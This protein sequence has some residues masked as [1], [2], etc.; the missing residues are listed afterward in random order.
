IEFGIAVLVEIHDDAG[1]EHLVETPH[2]AQ[3][4]DGAVRIRDH[5]EAGLGKDMR[6]G[7]GGG[8]GERSCSRNE[9][10]EESHGFQASRSGMPRY[11]ITRWNVTEMG[12]NWVLYASMPGLRRNQACRKST[13]V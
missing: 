7:E 6:M 12:R 3:F 2:V 9:K 8:G 4:A 5:F 13:K 11:R 1:G 10:G